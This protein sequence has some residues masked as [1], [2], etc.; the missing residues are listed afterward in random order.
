[1][2]LSQVSRYPQEPVDNSRLSLSIDVVDSASISHDTLTEVRDLCTEAYGVDFTGALEQ[3]GAGVH[4]IGRVEGRIVCRAMWVVRALQQGDRAPLRTAFIE[5]VATDPRFRRRGFASQL[6][7]CLV[8]ELQNFEL[9]ALSPSEERFYQR[10]GWER[11]RGSLFIRTEE[12]LEPT[13]D[14]PVMILRL[15]NTPPD[16]D[17]DGSLSAEW[18]HGEL[19]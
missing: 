16:L 13:P 18:R 3:L 14:E 5:A 8:R 11:W 10:L 9:A 2:T 1:M 15:E 7:T 19:W 17:I 12:G 4:V 6:L